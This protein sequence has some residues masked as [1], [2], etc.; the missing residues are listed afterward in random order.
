V[1]PVH[2]VATPLLPSPASPTYS[3]ATPPF[4]P[5]N[6]QDSRHSCQASTRAPSPVSWRRQRLRASIPMISKK[7]SGSSSQP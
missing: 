4:S 7:R 5:R 6:S 3:A 1:L 2:L